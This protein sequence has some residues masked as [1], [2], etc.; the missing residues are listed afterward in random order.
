LPVVKDF[1][2]DSLIKICIAA[3]RVARG[4]SL[5][6]IAT[7]ILKVAPKIFRLIKLLM[8]KP[9]KYFSANKRNCLKEPFLLQ[10]LVELDQSSVIYQLPMINQPLCT[11]VSEGFFQG[12]SISGFFQGKP[13]TL[14]GEAKNGEI[15]FLPPETKKTTFLCKKINRKMSNFK[16]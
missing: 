8:C 3:R 1:F 15:S 13:R 14:L 7:P 4:G 10:P 5:G 2:S 9:K 12:G 16:I 6:A 11:W